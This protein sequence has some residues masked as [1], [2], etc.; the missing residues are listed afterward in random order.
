MKRKRSL[1]PQQKRSSSF[2][3]YYR[4]WKIPKQETCDFGHAGLYAHS[5]NCSNSV[6]DQCSSISLAAHQWLRGLWAAGT[7]MDGSCWLCAGRGTGREEYELPEKLICSKERTHNVNK[8]EN[9]VSTLSAITTQSLWLFLVDHIATALQKL[10]TVNS[11]MEKHKANPALGT[12]QNRTPDL[13]ITCIP[14]SVDQELSTPCCFYYLLL[15]PRLCFVRF[16]CISPWRFPMAR[17]ISHNA[18]EKYLSEI[19]TGWTLG[20]TRV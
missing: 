13:S 18:C 15:P 11:L 17:I 5:M 6:R 7:Q 1:P 20:I 14:A 16:C 10:V 12:A 19:Q 8:K 4:T 3:Y 9:K 2:S